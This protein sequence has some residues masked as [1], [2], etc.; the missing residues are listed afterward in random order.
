MLRLRFY[1]PDQGQD[2]NQAESIE[3]G[4]F[5]RLIGGMLCRGAAND[6]VASWLGIWRLRDAEFQRAEWFDPVVIYFENNAGLASAAYGPFEGFH[7]SGGAAWA[8]DRQLARLDDR[9]QLWY[10]PRAADGWASLLVMPPGKSR[11]D[12]L[13]D[14]ARQRRP[15]M[16]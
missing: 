2:A 1:S 11:F 8:R 4:D 10:P 14:S 9:M 13:T 15:G 5:F 6:A 12:L 3:P 7:V 16:P